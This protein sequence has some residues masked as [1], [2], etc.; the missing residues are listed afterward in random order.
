M[1]LDGYIDA[2]YPGI[3]SNKDVQFN[4]S[5]TLGQSFLIEGTAKLDDYY[6]W[7]YRNFEASHFCINIRPAGG[8]YSD[9]W[10]VYASRS[11]FKEL[12]DDLMNGSQ[13]I[14][15]IAKTEFADTGSNNM[16]TLI[17]YFG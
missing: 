10:T 4:K 16:A 7:G 14:Y 11:D 2:R 6:N 5:G 3:I 15:L 9:E 17:D 13:N 12:Y 1:L 8:S